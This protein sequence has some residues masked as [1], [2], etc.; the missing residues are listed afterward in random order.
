[1]FE[2]NC[3]KCGSE[4]AVD[5]VTTAG[6]Y[7]EDADYLVDDV[8]KIVESTLQR[9]LVYRCLNCE[10]I[11]RYTY[12]EW[13]KLKRILI[14][15]EVMEMRKQHMF[16]NEI[17]PQTINVDNGIDFC[18]QCSGYFNDGTCL[19]DVIKQCTIRNKDV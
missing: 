17:N 13:E 4:L 16:R 3:D 19:K 9:Y 10:S 6:A 18:G 14:A 7:L 2:I 15:E 5:D 8:G 11:Y 1:M 12:K